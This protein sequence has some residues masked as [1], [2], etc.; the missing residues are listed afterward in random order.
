[1]SLTPLQAKLTWNSSDQARQTWARS[2]TSAF[3]FVLARPTNQ[4]DTYR[5]KDS[6]AD[7]QEIVSA[8]VFCVVPR[9]AVIVAVVFAV[10][11]V[12]LTVNVTEVLP[13]GTVTDLGAV[14]EAWPLDS[15]M[16]RPPTGA[17]EPSVTV[18]VL[19]FPPLTDAG[20]SV[21]DSNEGELIV[22]VADCVAAFKLA[23]MVAIF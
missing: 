6:C 16:T 19:D 23:E 7:D 15:D 9:V 11:A 8:A 2:P 17:G 22:S 21:T 1:M 20:F 13:T 10:T 14:A 12:V 5:R 3:L 18:P 4:I